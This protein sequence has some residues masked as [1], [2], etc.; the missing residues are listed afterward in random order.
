MKQRAGFS[1][2]YSTRSELDNPNRNAPYI[3]LTANAVSG[4]REQY[5]AEGFDD[6]LS[7]PIDSAGLEGML[8]R[9]LPDEKV[10]SF[11]GSESFCGM[12]FRRMMQKQCLL[13]EQSLW[14]MKSAAAV[15]DYDRIRE[16]LQIP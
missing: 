4:A 7:K 11:K 15:Y 3:C 14:Q 12:Y 16:L 5:L 8:I 1:Q 9:L 13:Q 10:I 6:Y 2:T